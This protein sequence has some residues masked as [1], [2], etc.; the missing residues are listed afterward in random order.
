M[1]IT[2]RQLI[3]TLM[4]FIVFSAVSFGG[5]N[6]LSYF[7]RKK[8]IKEYY[9]RINK[10]RD[11]I[12][13]TDNSGYSKVFLVKN[14]TPEENT[15]KVINLI[16]GIEKYIGKNSIVILKPNSQWYNQGMSNTN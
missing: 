16:G 11:D 2:R 8:Y 1:S 14:G 3:K 6:I 15:K 4:I 13:G 7:K 10:A 5:Y 12:R 9:I